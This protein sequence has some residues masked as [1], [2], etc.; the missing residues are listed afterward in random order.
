MPSEQLNPLKNIVFI[1]IPDGLERTVGDLKIDPS[2]RIPVELPTG[3]SQW[4]IKDLSWEMIV[5]GM[6]KVL[7]YQPDHPDAGYYRKFILE[8]KPSIVEELTATAILKA[9]NKDFEVAEEIFKALANLIPDDV[10]NLMNLALVYEEHSAA[11]DQIHNEELRDQYAERTFQ[12]YRRALRL[13]PDSPDVNYNAAHFFLRERNFVKAVEHLKRFIG[14]SD[15]SER[16]RRARRVV[17]ELES[18]DLLDNLFKEAYDFI[19]LGRERDGIA[20][21]TEFL[22]SHPDVWNAWFLLGWGNRRIGEYAEGRKAFER[23]LELGGT[24]PDT[25]NELAICLMELGELAES[26]RHLLTALKAEPE[27][28]KILSNLGI[29]SMKQA[30]S[31]EAIG[32]FQTVLEIEP[33]DQ[34]AQKYLELLRSPP[35]GAASTKS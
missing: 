10:R 3:E 33:D 21:I 7:A 32:F 17:K 12:V 4:E 18:Q 20:K 27:N 35:P 25:Y 24:Q 31:G 29:V 1:S 28:V 23:A 9:R 22:S 8:V 11:Y 2:V 14:H 15:D 30:N 13:D 6:L 5:A 16:V 34:I 26:R 19:R